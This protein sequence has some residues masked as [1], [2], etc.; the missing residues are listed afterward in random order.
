MICKCVLP[1]IPTSGLTEHFGSPSSVLVY[2]MPFEIDFFSSY[3]LG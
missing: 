1:V 2:F 3:G